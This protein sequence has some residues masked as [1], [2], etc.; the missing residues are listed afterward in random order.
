METFPTFPFVPGP[1]TAAPPPPIDIG[2]AVLP[3]TGILKIVLTPPAPPPPPLSEAPDPPPPTTK[4]STTLVPG[5]VVTF[6]VDVLVVT[7]HFPKD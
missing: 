3:E 4:A 1:G 7:V 2:V 5:C 6:T